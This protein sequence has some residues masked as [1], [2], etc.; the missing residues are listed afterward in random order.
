[1]D[2]GNE[3]GV[4]TDRNANG[5]RLPTEAEWEFAASYVDGRRK[6]RFGNGKDILRPTEANFDASAGNKQDYSETGIYREKTVRVGSLNRPNKLGI[7]D[8]SGNVWEWCSDWYDETYYDNSKGASNPTGPP[9]GSYRV[10]R[11][12]SW[13]SHPDSCRAAYR[14]WYR[15][16]YRVRVNGFRLVRSPRE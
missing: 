16:R 4:A 5:Y 14:Y 12:G 10:L 15:P 7:H 8:L 1:M 9:S 11:G 3:E 13:Y 2:L 6:A